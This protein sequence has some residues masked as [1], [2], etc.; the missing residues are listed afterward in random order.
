MHV[1]QL[2]D[3]ESGAGASP[4]CSARFVRRSSDRDALRPHHEGDR[5]LEQFFSGNFGVGG[6][7][8]ADAAKQS[9][10][11]ASGPFSCF[12]DLETSLFVFGFDDLGD[13]TDVLLLELVQPRPCRGIA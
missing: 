12:V 13:G 4:L 7:H 6:A 2:R 5:S 11:D 10:D 9:D 8:H 1:G 3:G